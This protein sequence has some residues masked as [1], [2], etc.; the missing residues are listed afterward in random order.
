M[1]RPRRATLAV[2]LLLGISLMATPPRAGE[3]VVPLKAGG[4]YVA[5]VGFFA[6]V[7]YLGADGQSMELRY[8][9][10]ETL[11][12]VPGTLPVVDAH[13]LL[14]NASN[15]TIPRIVVRVSIYLGSASLVGFPEEQAILPGAEGI[16]ESLFFERDY[17]LNDLERGTMGRIAVTDIDTSHM[18]QN[19][20]RQK[21]WPAYVR[22]EATLTEK[23][24]DLEVPV[25]TATNFLKI[26][27]REGAGLT[28]TGGKPT[29]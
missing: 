5:G 13:V 1:I 15:R 17:T 21:R 23:P 6:A 12:W 27:P 2:L 4:L 7:P 3:Q 25:P 26:V 16:Q 9:D 29:S 10:L 18:V 11:S 22:V 8:G 28:D 20:F 14:V 19:Q 24:E